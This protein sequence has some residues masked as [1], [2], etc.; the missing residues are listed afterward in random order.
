MIYQQ[1]RDLY[2]FHK[3]AFAA[4]FYVLSIIAI[5]GSI[6]LCASVALNVVGF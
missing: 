5:I 2:I 6:A 4:C 1:K 3:R